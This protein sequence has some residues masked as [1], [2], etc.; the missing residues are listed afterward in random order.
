MYL[1]TATYNYNE[2]GEVVWYVGAAN[3][4]QYNIKSMAHGMGLHLV[5]HNTLYFTIH[6]HIIHFVS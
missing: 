3:P 2:W 1:N 5:Y 4:E 6:T